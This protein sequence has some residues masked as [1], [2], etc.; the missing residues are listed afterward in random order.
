M[1][2][3]KVVLFC[4]KHKSRRGAYLCI[5]YP[6]SGCASEQTLV[7]STAIVLIIR[8]VRARTLKAKGILRLTIFLKVTDW[9]VL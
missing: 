3:S 2:V 7:Q 1:I 9:K 6:R 4:L 5:R 8:I